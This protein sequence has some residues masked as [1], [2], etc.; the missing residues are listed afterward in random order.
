LWGSGSSLTSVAPATSASVASNATT[1]LSGQT[2]EVRPP[3][4]L[5]LFSDRNGTFS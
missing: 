3:G 4:R 1:S 5:D 2:P